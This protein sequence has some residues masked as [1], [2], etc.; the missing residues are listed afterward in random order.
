MKEEDDFAI[1]MNK[2]PHSI[3]K[4][5]D[6]KFWLNIF[7]KS[8]SKNK[9]N[10]G[11]IYLVNCFP[12]LLSLTAF[13]RTTVFTVNFEKQQFGLHWARLALIAVFRSQLLTFVLFVSSYLKLKWLHEWFC[14][15]VDLRRA[16]RDKLWPLFR[17][18]C[19][20]ILAVTI[21]ILYIV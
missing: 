5:F 2:L 17:L 10:K 13:L 7:K 19:H 14:L 9:R 4:L 15:M 12:L 18:I 20:K 6:W 8:S 16:G 21:D 3:H 11:P 1:F